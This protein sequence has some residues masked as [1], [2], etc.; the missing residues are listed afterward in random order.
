MSASKTFL[1]SIAGGLIV[2]TAL[3]VVAF[4]VGSRTISGVLLWQDTLL[5][6]LIG[7]GPLLFVDA[8]GRPH[9]EGS[10]IV[11]LILIFGYTISVLLY[12]VLTFVFLKVF[13]SR[14]NA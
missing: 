4:S 9:Y 5:V 14:Q 2:A 11:P 3:H 6:Y 13:R 12:S 1:V 10:P 8:Q 7:P